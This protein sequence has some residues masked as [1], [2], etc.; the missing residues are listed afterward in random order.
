VEENNFLNVKRF[1]MIDDLK[2][3]L[4]QG[5]LELSD[6]MRAQILKIIE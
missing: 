6:E 2:T 1:T 5:K 3:I 4:H